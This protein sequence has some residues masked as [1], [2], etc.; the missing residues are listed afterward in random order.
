MGQNAGNQSKDAKD[1]LEMR[2]SQVVQEAISH[3]KEEMG[4]KRGPKGTPYLI[5][6]VT[7]EKQDQIPEFLLPTFG[8]KL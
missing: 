4:Q 6:A 7:C 5:L 8:T 3:L 1:V 2:V